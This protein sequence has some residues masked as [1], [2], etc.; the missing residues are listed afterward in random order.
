MTH[1]LPDKHPRFDPGPLKHVLILFLATQI[2][3]DP[4]S[5]I[6][7]ADWKHMETVNTSFSF[8]FA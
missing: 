3:S 2:T 1:V 7:Y 4:V 5:V 6:E 8:L